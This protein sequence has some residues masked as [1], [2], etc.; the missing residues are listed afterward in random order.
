MTAAVRDALEDWGVGPDTTLVTGG[1]R[2]ADIIAAEEARARGAAIRLVLA[3]PPDEFEHESVALPG[4]DWAARFRALLD[5]AD[6]EII[7]QPTGDDAFA[8]ANA[9]IIAI[10][11]G[12]DPEPYAL[13]VWDG[14]EGDGPGGTRDFVAR[15]GLA[16]HDERVRLIDPT[17]KTDTSEVR[18]TPNGV[19]GHLEPDP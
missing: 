19:A 2:G 5:V 15:L 1:A 14:A 12:L 4:T 8:R 6:V 9:R 10:A 13:I 17:P 3:L 18:P 11:R 7:E 16:E